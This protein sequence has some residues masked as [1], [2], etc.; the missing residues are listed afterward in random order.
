M[1][2][3]N[4]LTLQPTECNAIAKFDIHLKVQNSYRLHLNDSYPISREFSIFRSWA[5]AWASCCYPLKWLLFLCVCPRSSWNPP[6]LNPTAIYFALQFGMIHSRIWIFC[7]AER[8]K[9][10]EWKKNC[11]RECPV[12][13]ERL[14]ANLCTETKSINFHS[15]SLYEWARQRQRIIWCKC[16]N[17]CGFANGWMDIVYVCTVYGDMRF[18]RLLISLT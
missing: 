8:E 4:S 10:R 2:I 3:F 12:H 9:A 7:W 17:N 11:G 1:Q 5:S 18:V 15:V 16:G 13:V 6:I 14:L